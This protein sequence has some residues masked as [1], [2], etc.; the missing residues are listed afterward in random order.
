MDIGTY[1][2][3]LNRPDI[4]TRLIMPYQGTVTPIPCKIDMTKSV[5]VQLNIKRQNMRQVKIS[6]FAEEGLLKWHCDLVN[7][8]N[9]RSYNAKREFTFIG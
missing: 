8:I 7:Q 4:L 9:L 6:F 3:T 2:L 5:A 1:S